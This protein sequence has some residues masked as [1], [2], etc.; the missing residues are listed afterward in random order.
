ML[1]CLECDAELNEG[2]YTCPRCGSQSTV[3]SYSGEDALAALDMLSNISSSSKH[4][5]KSALL[6][7]EGRY[8]EAISEL[9]TAIQI[10]PNNATAHGNM[11]AILLMQKKPKE[12]I[13]WLEKALQL[14]PNLD[15][16]PDALAQANAESG[17]NEGCFIATACYGDADHNKVLILR[18]FRDSTMRKFKAGRKL[19]E[20]YVAVS[21][22]IAHWLRKKETVSATIRILFLNPIVFL[23]R[24]AFKRF[25]DE[26]GAN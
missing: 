14:N 22:A 3:G 8:L 2:T 5:D 4:V 26:N 19:I 13:P 17:Q 24:S 25:R 9:E 20:L 16:V 7:A 18:T 10:A 21:P 11:G 12:A 6:A 15:G 23:L 1:K